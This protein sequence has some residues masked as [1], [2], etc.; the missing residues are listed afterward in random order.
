SSSADHLCI[1]VRPLELLRKDKWGSNSLVALLVFL[2]RYSGFYHPETLDWLTLE[3]F[4]LIVTCTEVNLLE[5]R[6]YSSMHLYEL[7]RTNLDEL[8]L[9]L[10]AKAKE[11]NPKLL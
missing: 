6:L 7:D 10:S 1:F 3:Q 9:V 8:S 11:I 2:L 4:Q 5:Q